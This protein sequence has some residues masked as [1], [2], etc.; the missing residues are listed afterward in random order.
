VAM[1]TRGGIAY[2]ERGSGAAFIALHG[3]SLDRRMPIGAFEPLFG[4][5][6]RAMGGA[7]PGGT[8]GAPR[9]YRRIYP[10]LPFMGEST[11][12]PGGEG[13]DGILDAM[14]DFIAEVAPSGPLLLAGESYGGYLA[15]GLARDLGGRAKGLF[16]L[17]PAILGPRATRDI[18]PPVV[19][20]EEAGWRQSA[21]AR[22]ASEAELE[23]YEYHAVDRSLAG[24]ERTKAE[25]IAGIRMFRTE[26]ANRHYAGREAFSFDALGRAGTGDEGF[27]RPFEGPACFF[28]GRQDRSVGWRDALRL[29]GRYPRASYLIL[30]GAGHN[31]Q[32]ERPREFAAAFRSWLD[33]CE[34]GGP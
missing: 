24:F 4:P 29:A 17:C 22:G 6:G 25:V 3:Y 10:D 8:A 14:R 21:R 33:A 13:H 7:A 15:R 34:A 28:L 19:V 2:E 5:D 11:D 9:K 27:D 1:K 31:A 32:I 18:D 20:R 26:A 23:E 30:D 16:L 12:E